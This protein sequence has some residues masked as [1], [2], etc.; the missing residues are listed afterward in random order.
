MEQG[1]KENREAIEMKCHA[2]TAT[3]ISHSSA[4]L[5]ARRKKRVEVRKD[6]L[7]LFSFSHSPGLIEINNKLHLSAYI[8]LIGESVPYS[9]LIL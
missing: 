1:Q 3:V 8:K 9:Y 4:L 2:S 6:I 7:G 5:G